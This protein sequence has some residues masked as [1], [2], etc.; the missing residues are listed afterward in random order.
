VAAGQVHHHFSSAGEL[1]ALAFVH[2]IR[3]LLDA[4]QVPPPATWRARLHAMLGSE[5]GGF[6]PYIKLWREA[7]ILADRDPHIRDAYLLTM[8]MWH[9][10]TVTIIE[11]GKQAGEFTFTANATDIAWRLIALVCG[12]DGMYVLGIPEMADPAFKFHLDRMITLELF[13]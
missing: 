12:L 4:G 8:Q 11:Q 1:K 5:D 6:E 2:L 7:Q 13:A 10:E 9:E 3:T